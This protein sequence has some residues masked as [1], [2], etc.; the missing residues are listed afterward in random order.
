MSSGT[1]LVVRAVD[2]RVGRSAEV[3]VLCERGGSRRTL[4]ERRPLEGAVVDQLVGGVGLADGRIARQ[5]SRGRRDLRIGSIV[6][7]A[8]GGVGPI[9]GAGEDKGR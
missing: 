7:A 5:D 8:E 2:Q 1:K 3:A 6:A 9:T 4:L